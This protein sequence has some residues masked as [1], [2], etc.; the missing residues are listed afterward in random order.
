MATAVQRTIGSESTC[1]KVT[2][3]IRLTLIRPDDTGVVGHAGIPEI[4][5]QASHHFPSW[6]NTQAITIH[7]L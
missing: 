1:S 6:K 2:P 5:P 3:L 4:G 7:T